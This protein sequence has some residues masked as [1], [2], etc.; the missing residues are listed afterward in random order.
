MDTR[1]DKAS[2]VTVLGFLINLVLV[3]LKVAAGLWGHSTALIADAFHSFSDLFSDMA[4]FWGVRAADRPADRCHHYGH[5]KIETLVS[6]AISLLLLFAAVKIF[7]VG[8]GNI[9]R[10]VRGTV[11]PRPAWITVVIAGVSI[12]LKEWIYRHTQRV[13]VEIDSEALG[14]NAWHHRTDA[15]SSVA[16]M[17]GITGAAVLGGAWRV[18]DPLAAVIVS[19]FVLKAGL[20]IF[21]SSGNELMEASLSP[22]TEAEIM[23]IVKAVPGAESPHNLKTRRIGSKIAIEIHVRVDPGFNIVQA[24]DISTQIEAQLR[25]RYGQDIFVSVHVEPLKDPA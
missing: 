19:F 5:G 23:D 9:I 17:L 16:V 14:A 22:E 4:T 11:I 10:A 15:M 13:A 25:R 8:F 12:S 21:Y 24:H 2:R 7:I 1:I 6:L 20:G 18:L 3:C